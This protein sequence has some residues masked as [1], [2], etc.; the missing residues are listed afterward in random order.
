LSDEERVEFLRTVAREEL[1]PCFHEVIGGRVWRVA[2]GEI[3]PLAGDQA[4]AIVRAIADAPAAEFP[5]ELIEHFPDVALPGMVEAD[6]EVDLPY[7]PRAA[8]QVSD[9]GALQG[10]IEEAM[11]D[12]R[13]EAPADESVWLAYERDLRDC[14]ALCAQHRLAFSRS[15]S[16]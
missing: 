6:T 15:V 5:Y 4:D 7:S 16:D 9:I 14:M 8:W 11:Q 10:E 13:T 2:D 3:Q 1:V 12:A